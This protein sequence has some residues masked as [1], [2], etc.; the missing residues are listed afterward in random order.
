MMKTL[1]NLAFTSVAVLL[2]SQAQAL[3][4]PNVDCAKDAGN[5]RCKSSSSN[6]GKIGKGLP[7]NLGG[8]VV[9]GSGFVDAASNTAYVP[10]EFGSQQ[11]NQG[12]VFAVDLKTGDRKIISGYD[13]EEWHGKGQ[14]YVD[15]SGRK[16][17]AYDLGRV[18]V[19]RPGPTPGTVLALVDKGLQQRTEIFNIDVKTGDRRLVWASK[20]FD[21]SAREGPTSIRTIESSKVGGPLFC[22]SA[23]DDRVGLKPSETF[24]TDGKNVYMFFPN[25]PS[26]TGIGLMKVPV[27]GGKCEWVSQYWPDGTGNVGSG[28]TVNT[29]SPL[30]FASALVGKEWLGATGP[31]PGGNILF[32][33]NTETGARRTVSALSRNTPARRK[34]DGDVEVGYQRRMAFNQNGLGLT[35]GTEV[36]DDYFEPVAVDV[37]DG[38]RLQVEAKSGSLKGSGRDSY[39]NVV[40]AIPGTNKF[41]VAW[42]KALHV[43]DLETGSSYVLSQ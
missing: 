15:S 27:A 32:G 40:A 17:T 5:V 6:E 36:G 8:Y 11:D 26:G 37:K 19:V 2:A 21:D 7:F 39:G 43:Y 20:V 23:G 3:T 38:E 25:Q 1:R 34:G 35:M 31:N 22:K 24:E 33:I 28:A 13:G 42:G 12:A 9:I 14:E 30:L 29:L 10:V 4:L 41:I 16:Q 18:E